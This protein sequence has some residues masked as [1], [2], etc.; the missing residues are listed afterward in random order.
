MKRRDFLQTSMALG[1]SA[2]GAAAL[3]D[4]GREMRVPRRQF[5]HTGEMLSVIGLGGIVVADTEQAEADRLVAGAVEYG[6]NYFDVAPS[7]GNAQDILGP[8][9]EPWRRSVFLA[10]KTARRDGAGAREELEQS[11]RVLR[12]DHFDLY[13][14]HGLAS[15]EDLDACF[16]K[17][18]AMEVVLEAKERGITRHVGFSAHS[19]EVA[20]EAM[21]RYDFASVLFPFNCV[22]MERGGFGPSVLAEAKRRHMALLALKAMAWTPWPE[23]G[24]RAYPKCWY[25]PIDEL[26][27][28]RLALN[29]TLD[30][31]VT[32]AIPPGDARLFGIALAAALHPTPL[33]AAERAELLTA[34]EGVAPI[35]SHA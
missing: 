26:T 7:Y 20:L 4:G 6:I 16:A 8:A 1:L 11:L 29:Y 3:A 17:G 5:G 22:C 35:F 2:A 34:M 27:L 19:V 18:G 14:L 31:G 32:S 30:L 15:M 9:L 13:Q 21:R 10:C 23:G 24:E 33:G 25:R 12:T 28:A